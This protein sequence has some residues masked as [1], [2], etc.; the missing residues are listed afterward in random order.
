MELWAVNDAIKLVC[1]EKGYQFV[2]LYENI[3]QYSMNSGKL[4]D[5]FFFGGVHPNNVG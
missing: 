2:D 5:E 1:K 4:L 3:I